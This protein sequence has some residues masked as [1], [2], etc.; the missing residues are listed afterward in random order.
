METPTAL[1]NAVTLRLDLIKPNK[2]QPR[3]F[4]DENALNELALSITQHGVMQPVT[5]RYQPSRF[6]GTPYV[7]V[8]GQRRWMAAQRAGLEEIPALIV[9]AKPELAR[10]LALVEN[11]QRQDLTPLE[12]AKAV[13]DLMGRENLSI[14]KVGRRLGLSAG[15]VEKR[16]ALL[17]TRPD[18]RA[19]AAAHPRALSSLL[20]INKI[21]DEAKR[22][23][24]LRLVEQG[25]GFKQVETAVEDYREAQAAFSKSQTAP[26]AETRSR[27]SAHTTGG[28]QVSRGK[29]VNIATKREAGENARQAASA[30]LGNIVTVRQWVDHGGA[31]PKAELLRLKREV[32]ALLHEA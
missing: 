31:V 25:A 16:L 27:A 14:N 29:Q 24:M 32:E 1:E 19:V 28:G 7:L 22:G 12:E 11:I 21:N 10:E 13:A 20:L 4:F 18:V 6:D 5:V 15:W 30:A 8:A 23:E 9:D 26:D 2:E 17:K 3:Q